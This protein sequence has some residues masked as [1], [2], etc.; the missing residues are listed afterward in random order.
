MNYGLK[1]LVLIVSFNVVVCEGC[2]NMQMVYWYMS[3]LGLNYVKNVPLLFTLGTKSNFNS[4]KWDLGN[5][6]FSVCDGY[7]LDH[8]YTGHYLS[9]ST[10]VSFIVLLIFYNLSQFHCFTLSFCSFS[11]SNSY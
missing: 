8:K 1:L 7:A 4:L 2:A 6:N 5:R 11:R 3:L 10:M 9:Q